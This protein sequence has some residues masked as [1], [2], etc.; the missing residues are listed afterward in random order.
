VSDRSRQRQTEV[1]LRLSQPSPY[2]PVG[3]EGWGWRDPPCHRLP[4]QPEGERSGLKSRPTSRLL[5][6]PPEE[7]R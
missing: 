7:A 5:F 4:S 2:R 1:T 6:D 3:S